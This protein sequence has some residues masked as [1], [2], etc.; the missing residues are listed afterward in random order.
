MLLQLALIIFIVICL[1]ILLPLLWFLAASM[2]RFDGEL[3]FVTPKRGEITTI[4][5]GGNI[6]G[7]YGIIPDATPIAEKPAGEESGDDSAPDA[8][9]PPE[10]EQPQLPPQPETLH[11]HVN[12]KTGKI[13]PGKHKYGGFLF[14]QFGLV[15]IGLPINRGI[16]EYDFAWAKYSN[17]VYT[18]REKQTVKSLYT[19]FQYAIKFETETRGA[20][21]L[22]LDFAVGIEIIDS[23]RA[24]FGVKPS[25]S[26]LERIT[27][28]LKEAASEY[29][30]NVEL[31]DLIT[32]KRLAADSL[33]KTLEARAPWIEAN[34]GVRITRINFKALAFVND[35]DETAALEKF[36]AKRMQ[37]ARFVQLETEKRVI[38]ETAAAEAKAIETVKAA[39]AEMSPEALALFRDKERWTALKDS[40]L[41]SFV[42]GGSTAVPTIPVR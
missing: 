23:D 12:P 8:L 15:W 35:E 31:D 18:V 11:R 25:G 21:P 27:A 22:S 20:V 32:Q 16:Y 36:R 6:V 13:E 34:V 33:V 5:H 39:L 37:E 41:T 42:E 3:G 9:T 10:P 19:A 2:P 38:E 7:W 30:G 24:L 40:S 17:G 29:V 26:W 1:S 4:Q 28:E 14:N